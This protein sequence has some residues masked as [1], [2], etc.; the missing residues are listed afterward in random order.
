MF[1]S[2][3]EKVEIQLGPRKRVNITQ[4]DMRT[5]EPFEFLNDTIINFYLSYIECIV[6]SHPELQERI[7]VFNTFFYTKLI[8]KPTGP[9]PPRG[10][11]GR[12]QRQQPTT[13]NAPTSPALSTSTSTSPSFGRTDG[14][15]AA[16]AAAYRKR[17]P[18]GGAPDTPASKRALAGNAHPDFVASAEATDTVPLPPHVLLRMADAAHSGYRQPAKAPSPA[19]ASRPQPLQRI[20]A[21]EA[22]ARQRHE[23]VK[24]WTRNVDLFSKDFIFIPINLEYVKVHVI[25]FVSLLHALSIFYCNL[26]VVAIYDVLQFALVPGYYLLPESGPRC[27][28]RCRYCDCDCD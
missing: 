24:N 6:L 11:A 16:V 17:Q 25:V 5:L 10:G 13:R 15:V 19:A 23:N 8:A 1:N 7:H 26:C 21:S 27:H 20:Y 28:C 12:S 22:S 9:T 2:R 4:A 3:R 14:P 18:G